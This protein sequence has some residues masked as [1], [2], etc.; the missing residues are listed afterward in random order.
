MPCVVDI[1]VAD[2][3]RDFGT[4]RVVALVFVQETDAGQALTI[5]LALL[6]RRDVALEPNEAAL[7]GEPFAQFSGIEIGQIGGQELRR[8]IDVD[9]TARLGVE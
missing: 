9:Q 3:V 5:D 7:G 4:V 6:L 2:D 1:D 8:L